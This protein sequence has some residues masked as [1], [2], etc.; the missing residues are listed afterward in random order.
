[1]YQIQ[2]E[3]FDNNA[4]I[5]NLESEI[6]N[7]ANLSYHVPPKQAPNSVGCIKK[8]ISVRKINLI[9]GLLDKCKRKN[10]H[11]LYISVKSKDGNGLVSGQ[12]KTKG[13]FDMRMLR[14]YEVKGARRL[15]LENEIREANQHQSTAE[16]NKAVEAGVD[17]LDGG[18]IP[19]VTWTEARAALMSCEDDGR[20]AAIESKGPKEIRGEGIESAG[21]DES[22]VLSNVARANNN[23]QAAL[24]ELNA[25]R[26]KN[27]ELEMGNNKMLQELQANDKRKRTE[28]LN[29]LI[30]SS[31]PPKLIKPSGT[32]KPMQQKPKEKKKAKTNMD[33]E[34]ASRKPPKNNKNKLNTGSITKPTELLEKPERAEDGGRDILECGQPVSFDSNTTITEIE[35]VFQTDSDSSDSDDSDEYPVVRKIISGYQDKKTSCA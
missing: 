25:L 3:P 22:V 35:E 27:L 2:V 23:L 31:K 1:M 32:S 28:A 18:I 12:R 21:T 5:T 16:W 29:S 20:K 17:N 24:D 14:R 15:G 34:K 19:S 9:K 26:A 6:L 10:S 13:E 7:A 8:L 30:G 11:G 33:K 4:W